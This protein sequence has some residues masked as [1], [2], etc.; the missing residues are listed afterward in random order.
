MSILR[1]P[2]NITFPGA[3][4]PG[5][6]IWHIRTGSN[7]FATELTEATALVGYISS[8]YFAVANYLPNGVA[9]NIGTVTEEGTQREVVVPFTARAGAGSGSAPQ[10]LCA[11]VTWKTSI[12]ARRGRGRTFVGPLHTVS[13]QSD[14]T[15][16]DSVRTAILSAANA[17]VS[18]SVAYGNGAVGVWGYDAAKPQGQPRDPSDPKVFRDFVGCTVRDVFGILRSRRD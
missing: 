10:A 17:L 15:I 11:V 2:I 18:S 14:G 9:I 3:G 12:A 16:T 7:V 5:A 13:V 6:N 1:V 8:F 4:S